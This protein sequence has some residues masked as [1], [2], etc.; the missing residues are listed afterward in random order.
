MSKAARKDEAA[1]GARVCAVK[2][3]DGNPCGRAIHPAPDG[4]D[5]EPVCLMHSKDPAKNDAEFQAEFEQILAEAERTGTVA[6]FSLFVFPASNYSGRTFAPACR[7]CYASFTQHANF[8]EATFPQDMDF[9]RATFALGADFYRA[10]FTRDADFRFASFTQHADFSWATLA[11]AAIF[12]WASFTQSA[13]FGAATFTRGADFRWAGF[14]RAADFTR[15]TFTQNVDFTYAAFTGGAD[16]SAATF[17]QQASFW[18]AAFAK[19]ANFYQAR[20]T[21]DVTFLE[22]QFMQDAN[23]M[24]TTFAQDVDFTGAALLGHATFTLATLSGAATFCETRFRHDSTNWPGLEFRDVKIEHPEKVEL[25]RTDLGQ[26]LFYNTDVSKIKF[27]L[28]AWRDRGRARRYRRRRWLY[29]WRRFFAVRGSKAWIERRELLARIARPKR[30]RFSIFDEDVDLEA[31]RA[32]RSSKS[33]PDERNYKLIAE[34]YQQLKRN[35]DAK[36]DY[37]TAGHWHYGEMEMK[38][39]HSRFRSPSARWM[40]HHFSL[41]ALYKYA[42]AYGESYIMPLLWLVFFVAAFAFLYPIP[43]LEFNPPAGGTPGW[44]GYVDW[45]TFFRSHPAEH[46]AGFWGMTLHSLMTSLSVAGFQREL[47]YAPSYPW[48]RMLALFELLLTTTLGGLFLLAI[49]RQFKRS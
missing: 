43:G 2:M 23:F 1:Q 25:Y 38:R 30:P 14:T 37:W 44:L 49:R 36:G 9:S 26:A 46:P 11:Q 24:T 10:T 28:V 18:R 35:Y 17:A 39:L 27:T 40:S 12:Y 16:F 15:A 31:A 3:S 20:F 32:L 6:D 29:R 8:R 22:T 5:P 47:R 21:E 4:V 34:T 33:S 19:E 13:N 42:S 41:V 48:G 7:F 45:T